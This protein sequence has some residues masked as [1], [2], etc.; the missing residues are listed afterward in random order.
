MKKKM[1]RDVV[2]RLIK[3]KAN[4]M[5]E[6]LDDYHILSYLGINSEEKEIIAKSLVKELNVKEI[7]PD[8]VERW[9]TV[10]DVLQTVETS[11]S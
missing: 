2:I 1:P 3:E 11:A 6:K 10:K 8:V 9:N 4:F 5:P 7:T